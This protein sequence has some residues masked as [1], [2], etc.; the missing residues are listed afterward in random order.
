[1]MT[2]LV[3][4]SFVGPCVKGRS[5]DFEQDMPQMIPVMAFAGIV[6]FATSVLAMWPIWGLL[7][8]FYMLILT[9]G[10]T[11]SMMFLPGGKLGEL[12]FWVMFGIAA[13]VSHTLPHEP[14]W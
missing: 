7:T 13:Y 12:L 2:V 5:I 11:F 3:W 9:F 1:M 6:V 8:P 10:S 14:V 4:I